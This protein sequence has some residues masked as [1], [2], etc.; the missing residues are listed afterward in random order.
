VAGGQFHPEQIHR[1]AS[2][3]GVPYKFK[4]AQQ[5]LENFFA[6]VDRVLLEISKP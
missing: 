4:D 2:D 1:H 5:L 3:E 6:D